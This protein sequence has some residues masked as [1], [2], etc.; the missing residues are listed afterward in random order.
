MFLISGFWLPLKLENVWWFAQRYG[1]SVWSMKVHLR[2]ELHVGQPNLITPLIKIVFVTIIKLSKI[3]MGLALV[4]F[5]KYWLLRTTSLGHTILTS[6][7]N[8]APRRS[9]M[10][11]CAGE[12]NI[13]IIVNLSSARFLFKN[14]LSI[15]RLEI[16]NWSS[17]MVKISSKNP[18]Q[19]FI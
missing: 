14:S 3:F 17:T 4:H 11:K 6:C 19:I 15:K 18:D 7:L 2:F 8:I 10:V 13:P 16:L 9:Q 5:Q 1:I 12:V